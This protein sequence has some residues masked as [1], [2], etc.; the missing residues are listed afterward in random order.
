MQCNY[1]GM[2]WE[3][4]QNQRMSGDNLTKKVEAMLYR[5]EAIRQ[6]VFEKRLD[7]GGHT[8]GGTT[9]HAYVSD[10][11]ANTA[12]RNVEPLRYV[13]LDDGEVIHH[14][15]GWLKV[16]DETRKWCDAVKLQIYDRKYREHEH[17][18][19]VCDE[20]HISSSTYYALLTEIRQFCKM[21]A[22]QEQLIRIYG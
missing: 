5:E 22:L 21:A 19:V 15:E 13:R 10:P 4:Y 18:K 2:V 7:G 6:A 9:G 1:D 8:G 17:Y 3:L 14:P 11:T 16:I 20:L 12:T